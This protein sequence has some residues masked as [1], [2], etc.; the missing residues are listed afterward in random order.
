MRL[1]LPRQDYSLIFFPFSPCPALKK[2]TVLHSRDVSLLRADLTRALAQGTT[3]QTVF[4]LQ[5][6]LCSCIFH[7]SSA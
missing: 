6:T 7:L 4:Q 3:Q 5:G 1:H 2:T